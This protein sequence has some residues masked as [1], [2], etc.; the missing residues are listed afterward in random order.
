MRAFNRRVW[1]QATR[2]SCVK[3]I[4]SYS[5]FKLAARQ[6]SLTARWARAGGSQDWRR[7]P[8]AGLAPGVLLAKR[9]I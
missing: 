7:Y 2:E 9:L 4:G 6:G 5:T 1:N 3:N 8:L